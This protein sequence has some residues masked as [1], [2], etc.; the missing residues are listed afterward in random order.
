MARRAP[1]VLVLFG[2][3]LTESGPFTSLAFEAGWAF[4]GDGLIVVGKE[5][6]LEALTG[7]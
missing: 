1:R 6:D 3:T 5:S 4:A 2:L 7:A